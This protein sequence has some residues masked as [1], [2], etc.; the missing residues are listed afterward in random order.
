MTTGLDKDVL[1]TFLKYKVKNKCL[2]RVYTIRS[3][4]NEFN[5][6][7]LLEWF[8]IKDNLVNANIWSKRALTL[9]RT[10]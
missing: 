9:N 3:L 7:N 8:T 6:H 10:F 4:W 2:I 5:V 1:V